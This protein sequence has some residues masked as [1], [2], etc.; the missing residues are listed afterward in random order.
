MINKLLLFFKIYK[1][2]KNMRK[3]VPEDK[4]RKNISFSVDPRIYE[5]WEQYC[6]DNQIENYSAY[7]EKIIIEKLKNIEK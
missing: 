2:K 7:I 5:L 6:K 3:K 1:N 4:K